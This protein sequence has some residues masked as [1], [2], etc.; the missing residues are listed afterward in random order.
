MSQNRKASSSGHDFNSLPSPQREKALVK[1]RNVEISNREDKWF[2]RG[3]REAIY[4]KVEK[5]SLNRRGLRVKTAP[6][7]HT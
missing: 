2:G 7:S 6:V 5:L 1:K 4:V 3:I